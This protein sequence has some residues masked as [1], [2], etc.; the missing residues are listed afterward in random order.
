LQDNIVTLLPALQDRVSELESWDQIKLLTVI[1]D[2]LN[3]WYLP[4]LLCIGDSAHAMSPIGGVGINLAIQDAVATANLLTKPLLDHTL[5]VNDLAAVQKRREL[6]TKIIQRFQVFIQNRVINSVLGKPIHPKP[7]FIFK[8]L[9]TF[10]FLR[11]FPAYLIG[12]GIR[13][14]HIKK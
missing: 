5:T 6:P 11:F 14:E 13:S 3:Q 1:V 9:K 2:R 7:P 10:P 4:G 8:V 12:I